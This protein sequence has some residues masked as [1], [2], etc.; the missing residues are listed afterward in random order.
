[1]ADYRD[2]EEN[3]DDDGKYTGEYTLM[4]HY[5]D[6]TMMMECNYCK[7]SILHAQANLCG[8]CMTTVYCNQDCADFEWGTHSLECIKK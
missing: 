5:P 6:A 7:Q 8:R 1:M 3:Y 2:I 4:I